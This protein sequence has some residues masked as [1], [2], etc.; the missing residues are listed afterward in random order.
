[1]TI[2]RVIIIASNLF[3]KLEAKLESSLVYTIDHE[4]T[5][6]TKYIELRIMGNNHYEKAKQ[7]IYG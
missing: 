7:I 1:M 5:L 4:I 3:K 2:E 6:A